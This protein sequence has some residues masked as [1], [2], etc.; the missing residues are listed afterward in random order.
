M[1]WE[2]PVPRNC[3][4]IR[5]N[6]GDFGE[7]LGGQPARRPDKGPDGPAMA[8]ALPVGPVLAFTPTLQRAPDR[9]TGRRVRG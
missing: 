8:P 5:S 7:P 6:L 2:V 9:G 3:P 4:R 1:E